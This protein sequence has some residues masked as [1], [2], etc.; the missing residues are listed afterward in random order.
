MAYGWHQHGTASLLT[1][2]LGVDFEMRRFVAKSSAN[3]HMET[4]TMMHFFHSLLIY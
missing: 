1:E 2:H 3:F 4:S